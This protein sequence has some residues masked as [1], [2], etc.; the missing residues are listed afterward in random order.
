MKK[1]FSILIVLALII[2]LLP[3]FSVTAAPTDNWQL[4]WSDEF[5]GTNGSSPDSTKWNFVNQG[6]DSAITNCN[7][8]PT[9]ETIPTWKWIIGYCSEEGKLRRTVLHFS[10]T[11]LSK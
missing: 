7:T 4:V 10:Q 8:I 6:A 9:E 3:V 2:S 1:Y 11:D 5:T